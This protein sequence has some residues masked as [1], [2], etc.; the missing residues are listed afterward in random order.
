MLK[1]QCPKCQKSYKVDE[2]KIP[3]NGINV[4]CKVCENKFH[5][6]GVLNKSE[7]DL[8]IKK[9]LQHSGKN[10]EQLKECP[11][12]KLPQTG[13]DVCE[14]CGLNFE[15]ELK[16]D[17]TTQVNNVGQKNKKKS[18]KSNQKIILLFILIL[19]GIFA[20]IFYTQFTIFVI[21]PIGAAPEGRTLIISRLKNSKFIDSADAMCER[22]QG[23]VNIL[24]RGAILGAVGKNAKVYARL[25][26]SESLYLISTNGKIYYQ[27]K[28]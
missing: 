19:V 17:R 27:D 14:Y 24:C 1:I 25:P 21:Q 13:V 23:K 6:E 11:R 10:S 9:S 26:Y 7:N 2:H 4:K 16:A 22:I 15:N 20:V 8:K 28:K 3:L 5:V 12:C 18:G